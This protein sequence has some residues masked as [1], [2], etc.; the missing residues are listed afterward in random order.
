VFRGSVDMGFDAG[1]L[2]LQSLDAGMKLLDRDWIE[3]LLC[4]LYQRVARLARE[5]FLEVHR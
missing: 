2:G 5:E 4:K 3:I 1:N